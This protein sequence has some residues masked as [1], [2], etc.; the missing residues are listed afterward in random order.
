[1]LTLAPEAVSYVHIGVISARP[2]QQYAPCYLIEDIPWK[3]S[4]GDLS[5]KQ[6][7]GES[8]GS[9]VLGCQHTPLPGWLLSS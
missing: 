1:M 7:V 4:S 3:V 5:M 6:V 8:T 2:T 9:P